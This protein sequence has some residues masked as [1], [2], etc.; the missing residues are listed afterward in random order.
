MWETKL[1]KKGNSVVPFFILIAF[2]LVCP[3]AR[4]EEKTVI[5]PVANSYPDLK[6]SLDMDE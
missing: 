2:F 4:V 1:I 6:P 5:L 3:K